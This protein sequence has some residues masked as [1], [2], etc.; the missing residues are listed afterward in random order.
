[1]DDDRLRSTTAAESSD[2]GL[3]QISYSPSS[4]IR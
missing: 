1:M 4:L 3:Y 2:I